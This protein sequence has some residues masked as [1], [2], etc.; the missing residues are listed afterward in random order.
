[1]DHPETISPSHQME[2]LSSMKSVPGQSG[3][4]LLHSEDGGEWDGGGE[5]EEEG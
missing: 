3:G 4:G 5:A 2:K 1:M